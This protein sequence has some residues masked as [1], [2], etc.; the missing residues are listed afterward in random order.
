VGEPLTSLATRMLR[1]DRSPLVSTDQGV[2]LLSLH[3]V[4]FFGIELL[5]YFSEFMHLKF[6]HIKFTHLKFKDPRFISQKFI[7]PIQI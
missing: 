3:V 1:G 7:Y 6:I 5:S 2:P 4:S